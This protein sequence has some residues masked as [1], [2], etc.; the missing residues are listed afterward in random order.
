M[1]RE[2][3]D[4][5][6]QH[7]APARIG[8][9]AVAPIAWVNAVGS[10][11][12]VVSGFLAWIRLEGFGDVKGTDAPLAFL[13]KGFEADSS[14]LEF[15]LTMW[16]LGGIGL[17]LSFYRPLR[18]AKI[19]VGALA[20]IVPVWAFIRL[21]TEELGDQSALSAVGIG[22]WLAL[23]GAILLIADTRERLR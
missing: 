6:V 20:A 18:I 13:W 22:G 3:G 12:L 5:A 11:A 10:I 7:H 8:T 15:G 9:P 21:T 19:A 16:I 17:I 14:W 4:M 2:V 1:A 23:V